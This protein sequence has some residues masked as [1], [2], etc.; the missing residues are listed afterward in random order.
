MPPPPP[1][2]KKQ[3]LRQKIFRSL[4]EGKEEEE[5]EGWGLRRL[6]REAE[7]KVVTETFS[8]RRFLQGEEEE[9]EPSACPLW[10]WKTLRT[11]YVELFAVCLITGQCQEIYHTIIHKKVDIHKTLCS[12][13]PCIA[14]TSNVDP[15]LAPIVA[16]Y[17]TPVVGR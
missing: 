5:E 8:A 11:K 6:R 15:C 2:P 10:P 16:F 3:K 13:P 17:T 14:W 4:A 7:E 12:I 1:S 9:E